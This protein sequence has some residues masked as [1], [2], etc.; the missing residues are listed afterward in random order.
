MDT[1][2]IPKLWYLIRSKN[3]QLESYANTHICK[4]RNATTPVRTE[5]RSIDLEIEKVTIG[6]S[7]STSMLSTTK[8]T[9]PTLNSRINLKKINIDKVTISGLYV[10]NVCH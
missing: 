3:L 9:M 2:T 10:H 1:W 7:L 8:R 6:T 5:T 4:R